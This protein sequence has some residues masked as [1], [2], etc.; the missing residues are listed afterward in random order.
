MTNIARQT[1][2]VKGSQTDHAGE[3][4]ILNV[5]TAFTT[6]KILKNLAKIILILPMSSNRLFYQCLNKIKQ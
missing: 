3:M 2:I 6:G 4:D 1:I 5:K